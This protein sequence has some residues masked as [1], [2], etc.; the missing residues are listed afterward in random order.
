MPR[1]HRQRVQR[2]DIAA[3]FPAEFLIVPVVD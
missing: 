2:V 1:S 3:L